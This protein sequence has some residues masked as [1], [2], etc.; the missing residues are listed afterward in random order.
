MLERVEK[1]VNDGSATPLRVGPRPGQVLS[2]TAIAIGGLAELGCAGLHFYWPSA[3][4]VMG[5]F[6][7]MSASTRSLLDL[8]ILAVGLLLAVFGA[9]SLYF[10][11]RLYSGHSEKS[12]IV[13]CISQ[14]VL[15]LGRAGLE[16][17]YPVSVALPGLTGSPTDVILPG[18]V[19]LALLFLVPFALIRGGDRRSVVHHAVDQVPVP[20]RVKEGRLLPRIDYADA[21]EIFYSTSDDEVDLDEFCRA[22]FGSLPKWVLFLLW[23]R[24]QIVWFVGLR[25]AAIDSARRIDDPIEVGSQIGGFRVFALRDDEIVLGEDDDHL[26]FRVSVLKQRQ[27]SV[28]VTTVVRFHNWIGRAY[29]VPVKPMHKI[30]VSAM[31]TRGAQTIERN[32]IP[33]PLD[34]SL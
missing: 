26:D 16:L 19:A 28:V 18:A 7:G 29:F 9:L 33:Q 30:I 32:A 5:A 21:F 27:S 3:F 10:A 8:A 11:G 4:N 31:I 20:K 13:F 2:A 12:S 14:A 6:Q 25:A 22:V 34:S 17:A 23:L 15:W 1:L 24:D